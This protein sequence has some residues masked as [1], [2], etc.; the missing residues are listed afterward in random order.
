MNEI[1]GYWIDD[2]HNIWDAKLYSE[3]QATTFSNGLINCSGCR[4]CS[5]CSYCRDCSGCRDFSANPQRYLTPIIGSRKAQTSFYWDTYKTQVVCG[6]FSGTLEE[7]ETKVK[8]TYKGR[9]NHRKDYLVEI[10]KVKYL[11]ELDK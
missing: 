3:E 4:N 5:N 11:R 10:N 9:S 7:F 8:N 2:N 6:C 1:N